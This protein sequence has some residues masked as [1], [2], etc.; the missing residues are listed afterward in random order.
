MKAELDGSTECCTPPPWQCVLDLWSF[1]PK[2]QSVHLCPKMHQWQKFG[3]NPS[4]YTG[5]IAGTYSLR[6]V[7]GLLHW[8]MHGRSLAQT[9]ECTLLHRRWRQAAA[10]QTTRCCRSLQFNELATVG[11][12]EKIHT[13]NIIVSYHIVSLTHTGCI[14]IWKANSC[15]L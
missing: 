3:E 14:C 7:D 6:C 8:L 4:I 12:K 1:D 11:Q 9:E 15:K 10:L 2:T 5:D 13:L